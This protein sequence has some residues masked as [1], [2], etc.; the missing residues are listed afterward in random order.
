VRYQV[1]AAGC[2]LALLTYIQRLGFSTALPEIKENLGLNNEHTGYLA[3]AFLIAY[4]GFQVF[5]GLLGDR[6][7]ARH[8]LTILVLG[9]SLLTGA[10]AVTVHLPA[11]LT[12][13]FAF[14]LVLRFLFGMFQAGGFPAWARVIADWM[15]VQERGLAQGIVWT[16]SRL[17]GAVSPFVFLWLL[18]LFG[19]W[20]TPF[21]VVGG[22]GIAWCVCF[23][24]WF[25]NRPAEMPQVNAEERELIALGR[26]AG[27]VGRTPEPSADDRTAVRAGLP[28]DVTALRT[29]LPPAALTTSLPASSSDMVPWLRML[30]S[31]SVWGLCLMYGFLGFS[32]NFV[33][34]LLPVY[35]Q[36]HCGLT[37]SQT[38]WV[39]GVTLA[40]GML[41]C[42]AGGL[43]SDLL[44]RWTGNRKWGRRISAAIGLVVAGLAFLTVP[45]VEGVWMLAIWFGAAFFCNDLTMGPAWAACA[46]IA[47]R[48]AGTVSGAMNMIGAF[49]GAGG[50]ALAGVMLERRQYELLFLIF[51]CSY[52]AAA[53]C[54]LA[55]DVTKPLSPKGHRACGP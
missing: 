18:V 54:W 39:F 21:W 28:P 15:P 10:V 44:I 50:M 6:F 55:V 38:T 17:G 40:S 11:V 5:G 53:L 35:A 9:W 27:P 8:L 33:T 46:D 45:E 34:S 42:F 43:L 47:E 19:T 31:V 32:G 14:L 26:G 52:G 12:L 49:A 30:G 24:P 4:G 22:M 1:L 23:W 48:Y 2:L 41:A 29:G 7:G 13:Q 25:R 36:H 3:A 51:A 20:T 37:P 16:F